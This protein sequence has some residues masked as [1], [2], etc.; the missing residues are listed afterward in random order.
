MLTISE[1]VGFE[2]SLNACERNVNGDI[3]VCIPRCYHYDMTTHF[4]FAFIL[5]PMLK[6]KKKEM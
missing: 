1:C 2:I 6:K 3:Y 4:V 5:C